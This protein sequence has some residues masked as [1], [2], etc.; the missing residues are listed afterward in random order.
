VNLASVDDGTWEA[1]L[2]P[3]H[4]LGVTS[5]SWAPAVGIGALTTPQNVQAGAGANGGDG[6]EALTQ[7]KRFA[8]GGC[9]GLVKIWG[10]KSV[11]IPFISLFFFDF[12]DL[13]N[14]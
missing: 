7:V 2:F 9:D 10:W 11:R 8:T 5:V 4:S 12:A 3:A 14:L 6:Q 1:S 13:E